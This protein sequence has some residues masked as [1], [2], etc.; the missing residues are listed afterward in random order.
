M[1]LLCVCIF[2]FFF[3]TQ[4]VVKIIYS[5]NFYKTM[6]RKNLYTCQIKIRSHSQKQSRA[7]Y[8]THVILQKY[9][10]KLL[11]IF[12][13]SFSSTLRNNNCANTRENS[14]K[15]TSANCS[16]TDL[17]KAHRTVRQLRTAC[18]ICAPYDVNNRPVSRDALTSKA[19]A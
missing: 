8:T 14:K 12:F 16:K 17:S 11:K 9:M 6:Q 19:R 5:S 15:P 1:H 3:S 13:F 2:L 10:E 4:T 18:C 7:I